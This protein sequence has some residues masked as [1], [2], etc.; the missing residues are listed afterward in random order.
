M[1]GVIQADLFVKPTESYHNLQSNSCHPFHYK[2]VYHIDQ[3][4]RLNCI[5]SETNSFDKRFKN[6][7]RFLLE[8]GC[9]S[10]LVQ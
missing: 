4:L 1:E 9:N 8:R 5:C 10:K 2:K 3:A 6:S 7:K